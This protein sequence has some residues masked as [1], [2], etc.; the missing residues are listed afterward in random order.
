MKLF[1]SIRDSFATIGLETNRSPLNRTVISFFVAFALIISFS[2]VYL[3]ND[4]STFVE[5]THVIY[6]IS[7][8]SLIALVYTNTVI[9]LQKIFEL[10]DGAE[11]AVNERK[12][13]SII[14]SFE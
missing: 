5:C 10:L 8:T 14:E 13:I 3:F 11:I 1:L 4:V 7:S 12:F 6:M 2:F 9:K